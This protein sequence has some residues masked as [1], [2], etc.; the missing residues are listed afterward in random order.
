[1]ESNRKLIQI[2]EVK[3]KTKLNEIWGENQEEIPASAQDDVEMEE[4]DIGD[5]TMF[6]DGFPAK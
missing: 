1:M 5:N 2:F 6:V 3:I 4:Q